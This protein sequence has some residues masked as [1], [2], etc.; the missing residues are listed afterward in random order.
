MRRVVV[1]NHLPMRATDG[2]SISKSFRYNTNKELDLGK[3]GW[4]E[5]NFSVAVK[6]S[7]EASFV[8]LVG[9]NE[10]W[11]GSDYEDGKRSTLPLEA[12]KIALE[13]YLASPAGREDVMDAMREN[14]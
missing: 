11:V 3:T 14:F 7:V 1:H 9:R 2:L 12:V 13:R 8:G 5:I 4:G 6:V 10:W